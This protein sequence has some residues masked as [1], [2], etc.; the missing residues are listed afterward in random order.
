MSDTANET[1]EPDTGTDGA[2]PRRDRASRDVIR[3]GVVLLWRSARAHPGPWSLAVLGA[4]LFALATVA[5]TAVLGRVTDDVIVPGLSEDGGDGTFG[6][7]SAG[8]VVAVAASVMVIALARAGGVIA[9][10]FFGGKALYRMAETWRG[11]LAGRYLAA[12]LRFHTRRPAGVLMAHADNDTVRAVEVI[13]PAP[14][15][16]SAF[17]L[18]AAALGRLWVVDW[19][20]ALVSLAVF[21]TLVVLN[22]AYTSRVEQP[23]AR[24]QARY[25]EVASVA[26]ESFDGA[27]AVATLG[28]ADHETAR[29]AAAADAL[30]IE[31][32]HVGRLRAWFE[33]GLTALP[34]LGA[35]AVLGLGA[36]R[37]STGDITEGGI[38]EALAL[39]AVLALPMRV[40]GYLLQTMPTAAVAA[41]RLDAVLAVADDDPDEMH[42]A[43][44]SRTLPDGPL[45][46][47]VDDLAF[48]HTSG[49]PVL[50]GVTFDVEPGE[51]LALVGATAGGKS[52]LSLCLA[53]LLSPT[54]GH[55]RLGGVDVVDLDP[56]ELPGAVGIVLQETFLFADTVRANVLVS[57]H[58]DAAPTSEGGGGGDHDVAAVVASDP[59]ADELDRALERAL[60]ARFVAALPSGLDTELGERGV[61]LS[62]GQRQRLALARALV[63]RPRL[64]ILDD[65]TSAID[66]TVEEK[67]LTG[68]GRELE[69]TTIVV[70]HRVS[71]IRLADRVAFLD[72]GRIAGLAPHDELLATVPA[73]AALVRAYVEEEREEHAAL[74]GSDAGADDG[75]DVP[76]GDGPDAAVGAD[77]EVDR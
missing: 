49:T 47:E 11:D 58:G 8:T 40:M 27:L 52:T 39:F 5:S 43:R 64:L 50:D 60:A 71:T 76:S 36:W 18:G 6:S 30:R 55:V 63:R 44:G 17:V 48:A 22:R 54:S 65:A 21:P 46:V 72:G 26:H 35:V 34:N 16:L 2:A 67:I 15:S 14:M 19:A 23:A 70:A 61:T 38:V 68:L 9:R 25:G 3:R 75:G 37:L 7:V 10:R 31:R 73:Y 41:D 66:A 45:A 69:T 4:V 62:G 13:A 74:E 32:V 42:P 53:G 56:T 57:D 77:L 20:I 59:R 29:M 51:V 28:L 24:A 33:P 1:S 12:P